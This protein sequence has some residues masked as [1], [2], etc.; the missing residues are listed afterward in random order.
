[1]ILVRFIIFIIIIINYNTLLLNENFKTLN[2]WKT[3]KKI[4]HSC[5]ID[6]P[7]NFINKNRITWGKIE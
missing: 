2:D 7:Y 6:N 4:Y 5:D 3:I 1:M